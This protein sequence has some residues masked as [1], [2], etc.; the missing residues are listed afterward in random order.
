MH[1]TLILLSMLTVGH[2]HDE[3]RARAVLTLAAAASRLQQPAQQPAVFWERL[4]H[5][6]RLEEEP[7]R[8]ATK[9]APAV[10]A[11]SVDT[12]RRLSLQQAMLAAQR[13]GRP[14]VVWVNCEDSV[15]EAELKDCVHHH[16]ETWQGSAE[17][18]IVPQVLHGGWWYGQQ[19]IPYE[20]INAAK[21]RGTLAGIRQRLSAPVRP[22]G[23]TMMFQAARGQNC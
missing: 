11:V 6:P 17:S 14:L 1:S 4:S 5:S 19:D 16:A 18:R 20:D 15:L 7:P 3:A 22:A 10:P 8:P 21:V 12:P 2:E 13:T 9:S 23:K